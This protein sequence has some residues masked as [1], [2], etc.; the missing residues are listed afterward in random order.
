MTEMH[1]K[2]IADNGEGVSTLERPEFMVELGAL[3]GINTAPF[4]TAVFKPGVLE[5]E[6]KGLTEDDI[7]PLHVEYHE[8]LEEAEKGHQRVVDEINAGTLDYVDPDSIDL[9]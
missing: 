7:F 1:L 3:L 2:T 8:T 5:S 6:G 9:R 4:E